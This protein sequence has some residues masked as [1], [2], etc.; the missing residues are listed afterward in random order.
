MAKPG[1]WNVVQAGIDPSVRND[2]DTHLAVRLVDDILRL[3]VAAHS[4][5]ALVSILAPGLCTEVATAA[6][7][8]EGAT[9]TGRRVMVQAVPDWPADLVILAADH[10]SLLDGEDR[11]ELILYFHPDISSGLLRAF[12]PHIVALMGDQGGMPVTADGTAGL[13][14]R[15]VSDDAL[16]WISTSWMS[17]LLTRPGALPAETDLAQLDRRV[18]CSLQGPSTTPAD[19]VVVICS[20]YGLPKAVAFA[21]KVLA[22]DLG[23]AWTALEAAAWA[24]GMT[25]VRRSACLEPGFEACQLALHDGGRSV[26]GPVGVAGGARAALH[27]A[28]LALLETLAQ[29]EGH[30]EALSPEGWAGVEGL[31]A[32]ADDSRVG[33]V[34]SALTTQAQSP[35]RT[36]AAGGAKK[37]RRAKGWHSG[38]SSA[39]DAAQFVED[40]KAEVAHQ[41]RLLAV[42]DRI[43][44]DTEQRVEAW[45]E[46][47]AQLVEAGAP[48]EEILAAGAAWDAVTE[49][50]GRPGRPGFQWV[51]LCRTGSIGGAVLSGT[52]H[53]VGDAD[54]QALWVGQIRQDLAGVDVLLVEG[55][56]QLSEDAALDAAAVLA[57]AKLGVVVGPVADLLRVWH[58]VPPQESLPCVVELAKAGVLV[59]FETA[60]E[61]DGPVTVTMSAC[62]QGGPV[63]VVATGA[64]EEVAVEQCARL[65]LGALSGERGFGPLGWTAQAAEG[66]LGDAGGERWFGALKRRATRP[67]GG[68]R[69]VELKARVGGRDVRIAV[70]AEVEPIGE[71]AARWLLV[72]EIAGRVPP[73]VL[74]REPARAWQAAAALC[75]GGVLGEVELADGVG[76]DGAVVARAAFGDGR[77]W[78][79]GP[80]RDQVCAELLAAVRCWLLAPEAA[81]ESG[82]GAPEPGWVAL[83]EAPPSGDDADLTCGE[84]LLAAVRAGARLCVVG[85]DGPEP[86]FVTFDT[87][88]ARKAKPGR[89]GGGWR[90]WSERGA[91][92]V[93]GPCVPVADAAR[94]LL[95]ADPDPAWDA[96]AVAWREILRYGCQV[97]AG[98]QVRPGIRADGTALW[99]PG[100]LG[101][102]QHA[103]LEQLAADLPPWAHS[104]ALGGRRGTMLSARAA[105]DLVLGEL[106]DALVCGPGVAAIWGHNALT[107]RTRHPVRGAA[108]QWLDALE[109]IAD[110]T[111]LPG[112]VVQVMPPPRP[113]V[114]AQSLQVSV[115]L[116]PAERGAALVT[117]PELH[118]RHGAEH[119][120]VLRARRALR[121]AAALWSPLAAAGD[122]DRVRVR[123]GEAVLLLGHLGRVLR[124]AGVEVVWPEQWAARLRATVVASGPPDAGLA[125]DQLVDYRWQLRLDGSPL[126]PEE[127]ERIAAAAGALMWLRNRWVLVDEVTAERAR[128]R[129]LRRGVP[130]GEALQAVLLGS[131]ELEGGEHADVVADGGLADLADLLTGAA[132][133][134]VETPP[135]LAGTLWPYQSAGLTWLASVTRNFGAILADEMGLGKTIQTIALILHRIHTGQSGGL[136]V[137]VV[138]PASMVLTWV[139]RLAE[140]AP[141]VPV[142]GYHGPDRSLE[143]LAADEV[144]VT[145]YGTL[146]EDRDLLTG[147]AFSLVV[148]DEAQ[149]VKN[150]ASQRAQALAA[151][152]A[153]TRLALTGTPVE[154]RLRDLWALLNWTNP[155]LFTSL[156]AFMRAFGTLEKGPDPKTQRALNRVV[157]SVMLRRRKKHPKV[158]LDLPEKITSR[159]VLALTPAQ[160]GLYT[161]ATRLATEVLR[162]ASGRDRSAAVLRLITQLRQICNSPLHLKIGSATSDRLATGLA[163]YDPA[164]ASKEASKLAALDDLV[165]TILDSE[166]GAAAVLFT[167]FA[168][169]A[170]VLKRHATAWGCRPLLYTGAMT[171]G[172]RDVA[173]TRFRDRHSRLLIVTR[174]SGG[175]GLDLV[176]A[177]HAILV[178]T[179]FNPAAVSQ[180]VDRLHRPGQRSTVHVHHL[181]TAGTIEEK[182]ERLLAR[183]NE[184]LD[185][186]SPGTAFDPAQLSNDELYEL[187]ALG[188][189][190]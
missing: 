18:L 170:M 17:G 27:R 91:L 147:Q 134:R 168:T 22:A 150:P 182:I 131:V 116:R 185:A 60:V 59:G 24:C 120:A 43:S 87:A 96:S 177:N 171:S 82:A 1:E 181:Q 89:G 21:W 118:E 160:V 130:A 28:A 8:D 157:G 95:A 186:L 121:K 37:R 29:A 174:G 23:I 76:G 31:V 55:P 9:A 187:I 16:P 178:D 14:A 68:G 93:P 30:G 97:V 113:G 62:A 124:Q 44:S 47:L 90:L 152:P 156:A 135:G 164:R 34:V 148:A 127:S 50:S 144:V 67:L 106:T 92:V 13:L 85:V 149:F 80:D 2:S 136:P 5:A 142:R 86:G 108:A 167:E 84:R 10:S 109:E 83:F 126:S 36:S 79:S 176:T 141:A 132:H 99:R 133:T 189:A 115:R 4:D 114:S 54:G 52:A 46:R 61:G 33:P 110:P 73:A 20:S 75:E 165:P 88:T 166:P 151:V 154:N 12:A 145:S 66:W 57:A 98:G 15:L 58:L 35:G 63:R 104:A 65:L 71:L 180:A 128:G 112:V 42:S 26:T 188:T 143:H 183:K 48:E 64:D 53:R 159:H 19:L 173:L 138:A 69:Q 45:Q 119:P 6:L 39:V 49:R 146:L 3:S 56:V 74:E 25:L 122:G 38:G 100:P 158:A 41:E 137:L 102:E 51:E 111:P 78:A 32:W 179:H 94:V 101:D 103:W 117:L 190:A 81:E 140:F 172:Q 175:T 11:G 161:R 125:L 77:V 169:M 184:L 105:A 107:A 139:R 7:A 129:R 70:V 40:S 155:H 72:Q 123:P 153:L 162:T 163:G